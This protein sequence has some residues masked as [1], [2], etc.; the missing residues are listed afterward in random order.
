MPHREVLDGALVILGG[1]FLLTPGFIT[2]V[3]GVLLLLPPTRAIGRALILSRLGRQVTVRVAGGGARPMHS[4]VDGTASEYSA[5]NVGA[6]PAEP[7]ASAKRPR[8]LER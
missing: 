6:Q 7:A 2:D 5:E 8:K 3:F 4:D 1:A